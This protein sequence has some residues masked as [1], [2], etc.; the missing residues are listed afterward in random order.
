MPTHVPWTSG[1]LGNTPSAEAKKGLNWLTGSSMK[2]VHVG[3]GS[4]FVDLA[5]MR[6][7][8]RMDD[9]QGNNTPRWM[10]DSAPGRRRRSQ[11]RPSARG[12]DFLN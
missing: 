4:G 6:A 10:V 11:G 2:T 5:A 9:L 1:M 12:E 3:G 7:V 8:D